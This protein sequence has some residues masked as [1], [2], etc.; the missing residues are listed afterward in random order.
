MFST[1]SLSVYD[2]DDDD[3]DDDGDDD[4]VSLAST[5]NRSSGLFQIKI[6]MHFSP[7]PFVLLVKTGNECKPVRQICGISQRSG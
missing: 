6:S 1:K 5:P 7:L 3:D 4:G 2:D